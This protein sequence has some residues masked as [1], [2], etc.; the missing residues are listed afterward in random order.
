LKKKGK[1]KSQPFKRYNNKKVD[2]STNITC[3]G[4]GKQGHIKKDCPNQVPKGKAS[5]KKYVKNKKQMRA[6]IAWENNDTSSSS[7]SDKEEEANLCM[8]A[9][10]E[11]D[12][13]VSSSISFTHENYSTLLNAFK[14]THEEANQLA[15]SNNKLKGLNNWLENGV[16]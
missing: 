15:L 1:E 11:S 4:C 9:G 14:E 13:S 16:K 7:S 10:H 2:N 6:Y 12:S 3:F 5:E 8:M